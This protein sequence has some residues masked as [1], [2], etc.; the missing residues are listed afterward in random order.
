MPDLQLQGS[1]CKER[2]KNMHEGV[3]IHFYRY[4]FFSLSFENLPAALLVVLDL[5]TGR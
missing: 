1:K 5:P 3:G 4:Y 2:A